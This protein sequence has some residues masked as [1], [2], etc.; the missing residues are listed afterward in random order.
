M[1]TATVPIETETETE[2][3]MVTE[4]ELNTNLELWNEVFATD[5]HYTKLVKYGAREFTAIDAYYQILRAT[6]IF[7]PV[8]K[9][10]GWKIVN[11]APNIKMVELEM[12]IWYKLDG[13]KYSYPVF[14]CCKRDKK[15]G[16]CDEDAFK[17]AMTDGI[18]KGLSLLG[19]NA[20]VFFGLHD[21][22]KY[23][24]EQTLAHPDEERQ[25]KISE[26]EK[27]F[28]KVYTKKSDQKTHKE[29]VEEAYVW[30]RVDKIDK[31]TNVHIDKLINRFGEIENERRNNKN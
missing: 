28:D 29:N 12:E 31:M 22:S 18:T 7:G 8:G 20:D 2:T 9:G 14:G 26:L 4:V 16:D 19:F 25:E 21:D 24:E 15:N 11:N 27:I 17:K 30:A 23:V 5:P 1:T 6:E 10:W 13:E 3:D